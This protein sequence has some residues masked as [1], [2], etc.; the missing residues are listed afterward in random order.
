M[1]LKPDEGPIGN[2][3]FT[4]RITDKDLIKAANLWKRDAPHE[5]APEMREAVRLQMI[6]EQVTGKDLSMVCPLWLRNRFVQLRKGKFLEKK[7]DT[8]P[9]DVLY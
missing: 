1:H 4:L 8:E 5:D 6:L 3:V 7:G 2:R 9:P